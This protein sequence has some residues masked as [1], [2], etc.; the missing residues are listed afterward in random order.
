MISICVSGKVSASLHIMFRIRFNPTTDSAILTGVPVSFLAG[1]NGIMY[2]E[3]ALSITVAVL[4]STLVALTLSPALCAVL[5]KPK[6]EPWTT[7][8]MIGQEKSLPTQSLE[9]IKTIW[10]NTQGFW[11]RIRLFPS[12]ETATNADWRESGIPTTNR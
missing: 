11:I 1:V 8:V 10:K 4:I 6:D 2:R 3:F 9:E 5:L 12:N 7:S